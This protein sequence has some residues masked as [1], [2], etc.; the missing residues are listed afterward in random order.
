MSAIEPTQ[1]PVELPTPA[2]RLSPAAIA[3]TCVLGA[4]VVQAGLG[5]LVSDHGSLLVFSLTAV[6][7]AWLGRVWAGVL[8]MILGLVVGDYFFVHPAGAPHGTA[9]W[10]YWLTY[11]GVTGAGIGLTEA[12]RRSARRAERANRL[13][14][15]RA[16]LL[17]SGLNDLN[18]AVARVRELAAVVESSNDA[19]VTCDLDG[20][21]RAWN[22][23]AERLFGYSAAE[24]LG[25]PVEKIISEGARS[26]VQ[27]ATERMHVLRVPPFETVLVA[28][29]GAPIEVSLSLSPV[30][31]AHG[32]AAAVAMITRDI[33]AAKRAEEKLKSLNASLERSVLERTAELE[34]A[35]RELE[36]FSYSVSHDLRA[37]LRSINGFSQALAEDYGA[38]L[39][40][41]GLDYLKRIRNGSG[42]MGE[43]IEDLLKLSQVTRV[44]LHRRQVNLTALAEGVCAELHRHEPERQVS[45][46]VASGLSAWGDEGLVRIALENLLANAWKFTARAARA[47]IEVGQTEQNGLRVVFVRDNGAGFQPDQAHRL[48]G[49]FQRLH[50]V[51]EFPGTGVGL[52]T[53]R[54][55]ISRHGGEIWAE[56]E[57]GKGATFYFTLPE[58]PTVA[59]V[60]I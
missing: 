45:V 59:G 18:Q 22:A 5:P 14:E 15:N 19:I 46:K 16:A 42:R 10:I 27:E 50:S 32:K 11:L 24:M 57:P 41:R 30:N 36:T 47:T 23:A 8:A 21:V 7:A 17:S 13:A 35:N 34:A 49:V 43:L 54:R 56:G 25:Q 12:S 9:E 52:A 39:D 48:F 60:H 1:Q 3:A 28:R 55:I 51:K 37:P 20:R 2:S 33:S 38:R 29:D 4:S 40:E 26:Q 6:L 53:V 31:D 58:P 44:G